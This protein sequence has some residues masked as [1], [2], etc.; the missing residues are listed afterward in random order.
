MSSDPSLVILNAVLFWTLSLGVVST[1]LLV[2][3]NKNPVGSALSLVA[4]M[5]LSS[6]LMI[7]MGAFFLGVVQVLV[8]AGAVMVLFLFIIMLLDLRQ[9]SSRPISIFGAPIGV[10]L[11]GS[12]GYAIF[13]VAQQFAVG[14]DVTTL[15]LPEGS[16]DVRLLGLELF[17][18]H[19]ATVIFVGFL[20]LVAMVGVI[21][22]CHQPKS[23]S[24]SGEAK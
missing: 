22:L 11:V 13:Q 12:L 19:A 16:D 15:S 24:K 18:E 23:E 5:V 20:L 21:V 17:S 9:E 1:A 8:Y 4:T 14:R 7:Q 6:M 10:V 2:V 3:L